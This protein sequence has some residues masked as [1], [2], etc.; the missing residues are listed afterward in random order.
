MWAEMVKVYSMDTRLF[1]GSV[2]KLKAEISKTCI[3]F[4]LLIWSKP[5]HPS[6]S[7]FSTHI[8]RA[9][10]T[11]VSNWLKRIGEVLLITFSS[12]INLLL[13]M[14]LR[15]HVPSSND[16]IPSEALN[17]KR[18]QAG[19][20]ASRGVAG[21]TLVPP[22]PNT[23]IIIRSLRRNNYVAAVSVEFRE[24]VIFTG[25]VISQIYFYS[26]PYLFLNLKTI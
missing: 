11:L 20:K 5:F 18:S 13:R 15:H 24:H 3:L 19:T 12:E 7:A 6:L 8:I 10:Q 9:F 4:M 16:R 14:I 23:F 2:L 25:K 22:F 17:M 26:T 1:S 21:M